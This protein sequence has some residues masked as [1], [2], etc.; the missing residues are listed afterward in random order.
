MGKGIFDRF[1]VIDVDAHLT[2]PDDSVD[3]KLAGIRSGF[4]VGMKFHL[5]LLRESG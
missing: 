3:Q 5:G 1:Q 4:G 2:G